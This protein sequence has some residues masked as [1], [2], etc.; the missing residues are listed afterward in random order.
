MITVQR[1]KRGLVVQVTGTDRF[2]AWPEPSEIVLPT[3]VITGATYH[4]ALATLPDRTQLFWNV[5]RG[6]RTLPVVR[7]QWAFGRRQVDTERFY[8]AARGADI[9]VLVVAARHWQLNGIVVST[10]H[11]AEIAAALATLGDAEEQSCRVS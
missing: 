1:E 3:D 11:A 10:P 4:P 2:L 8:F 9:P 5:G 7:G 6:M